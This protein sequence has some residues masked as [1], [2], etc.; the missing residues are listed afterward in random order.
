MAMFDNRPFLINHLRN[1]FITSD[2]SGLSEIILDY[3]EKAQ[4]FNRKCHERQVLKE[5]RIGVDERSQLESEEELLLLSPDVRSNMRGSSTR[6]RSDTMNRLDKLKQ[7]KE[8]SSK[9]LHVH[10]TNID[11]SGQDFSSNFEKKVVNVIDTA[12]PK[13]SLLTQQFENMGDVPPNPFLEYTKFEGQHLID[14]ATRRIKVYPAMIPVKESMYPMVVNCVSNAKVSDFIGLICWHYTDDNLQPPLR[15]DTVD[16]YK[17]LIAEDDGEIDYDIPSLD[18][19]EPITKYWFPTLALEEKEVSSSP[20]PLIVLTINMLNRGSTKVSVESNA[21]T[22]GD[23]LEMTLA[24][25]Q[26]RQ[27][28]CHVYILEKSSE[29]GIA[30]SEDLPLNVL[31]TTEFCLVRKNSNRTV[32][33][34]SE[35]NVPQSPSPSFY[36]YES[37]RVCLCS[38]RLSKSDVQL[39]ISGDR[40]EIDHIKKNSLLAK[41]KSYSHN[42]EEIIYCEEIDLSSSGKAGFKITYQKQREFKFHDFETDCDTAQEILHKLNIILEMQGSPFRKE[43]MRSSKKYKSKRNTIGF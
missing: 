14:V 26:L 23:I 18:E 37:F 11:N 7:D 41:Q 19:N 6:K 9:T 36:K 13:K 15:F 16:H 2:D 5:S 17:L 35:D 8:L 29:P 25:R 10:W 24:K 32:S 4:L 43:L 42:I 1:A 39:G 27:D 3:E 20:P 22:V 33:D 38:N 31:G 34:P 40:V 21:V 12:A 30:L 28:H